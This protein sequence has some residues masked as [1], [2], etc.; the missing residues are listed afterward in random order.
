M[1]STTAVFDEIKKR[2][3][4][5]EMA[6]GEHLI[7]SKL[8]ETFN[9]SRTPVRE[10]LRRLSE[11]GL[12][13]LSKNQG[14]RVREWTNEEILDSY[15]IREA[16]ETIA[17]RRAAKNI[18]KDQID[19]LISLNSE[20]FSLLD[21][22]ALDVERITELNSK[23]HQTIVESAGSFR[24]STSIRS[25][26][27]IPLVRRTFSKYSK[28]EL[29]RSIAHHDELI[30]AFQKHDA[31]WASSVMRCHIRAASYIVMDE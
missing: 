10:A 16:L 4:I 3:I 29:K 26:V 21:K 19:V 27:E 6:P 22:G 14:V 9:I 28:A 1:S 2:I 12:V 15:E 13:I 11:A 5:G 24:L 17:A 25:V 31:E 30:A 18:K 7:E 23:F 8:A 20:M